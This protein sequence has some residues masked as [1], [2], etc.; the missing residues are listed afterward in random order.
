LNGEGVNGK[1][2]KEAQRDITDN[3]MLSKD[4]LTACAVDEEQVPPRE[5]CSRKERNVSGRKYNSF[6]WPKVIEM[7][8]RAR[9]KQFLSD[10]GAERETAT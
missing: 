7:T 6:I 9:N 3:I 1:G 10:V 8:S 4:S 5:S 2:R